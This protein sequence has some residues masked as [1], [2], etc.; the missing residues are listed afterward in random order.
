MAAPEDA[1]VRVVVTIKPIHSLVVGVLEG[2]ATPRLLVRGLAS[3]HSF[4]LRPSDMRLL[5]RS[6]V[7]V[8][9][10][11]Q[12]EPFVARLSRA[13]PQSTQML[14]LLDSPGLRV[15]PVRMGLWRRA[16]GQS[17]E[18]KTGSVFRDGHVWLDPSNGKKIVQFLADVFAKRWPQHSVRIRGNA[19]KILVRID[20]VDRKIS[21]VLSDK[22][23]QPYI[24]FHDA[25]Q[26]FDRYYKLSGVGA[27]YLR[28]DV[29]PSARRLQ[30]LRQAMRNRKVV[31]A[32]RDPRLGASVVDGV[33]EGLN[34]RKGTLDPLGATLIDGRDLYFE[35]LEKIGTDFAACLAPQP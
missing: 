34:V 25:F 1:D 3:P 22:T 2:I 32:F 5:S 11:P 16:N 4:R 7:V 21:D 26:Y 23:T 19:E 30:L 8:Y 20:Q 33:T 24:V 29:P 9:I 12:I 27:V 28:P 13:L 6:D 17:T 15:W 35:L 14:S 10:G 18:T 31:C